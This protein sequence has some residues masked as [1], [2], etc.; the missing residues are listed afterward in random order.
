MKE[1]RFFPEKGLLMLSGVAFLLL[2]VPAWVQGFVWCGVA[3]V[4]L[5]VAVWRLPVSQQ[6][7]RALL[8]NHAHAAL[9]LAFNGALAVNFYHIWIDSQKMQRV[10]GWLGMENGLFAPFAPRSLPS[11]R[12]RRRGA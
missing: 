4:L 8:S 12:L 2:T 5:C 1:K 10:A 11:R 7:V 9:S 6:K 3:A